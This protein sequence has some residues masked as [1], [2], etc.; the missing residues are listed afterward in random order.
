MEKVK[1]QHF[2]GNLKVLHTLIGFS[3][4]LDLNNKGNLNI[5]INTGSVR[6]TFKSRTK[7]LTGSAN[8]QSDLKKNKLIINVVDEV[9]ET[10]AKDYENNKST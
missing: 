1:N 9:I 8:L 3:Y 7:E 5:N 2:E 6:F 4:L 10:L